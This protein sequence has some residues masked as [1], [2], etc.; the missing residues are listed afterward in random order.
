M[1]VLRLSSEVDLKDVCCW[2]FSVEGKW[3]GW[4]SKKWKKAPMQPEGVCCCCCGGVSAV[5]VDVAL[6]EDFPTQYHSLPIISKACVFSQLYKQESWY[7]KR[8]VK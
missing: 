2:W 8:V 1:I 7:G 5:V 6:L 3:N 4:K